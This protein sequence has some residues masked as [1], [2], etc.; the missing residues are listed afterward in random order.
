MRKSI[1]LVFFI[2]L[3]IAQAYSIELFGIKIVDINQTIN[4]TGSIEY[5]T[6]TRGIFD[7][8]FPAKNEYKAE[9]DPKLFNVKTWSKSIIQGETKIFQ[10]AVVDSSG[11]LTYDKKETLIIKKPFQNIFSLLAMVQS[12]EAKDIDTKWFNYEHEGVLGRARFVWADSSNA[13]NGIDSILCDHYRLDIELSDSLQSI[14][15]NSD[16]FM[17]QIVLDGIIK[18]LWVSRKNPKNII[19]AKIKMSLFPVIA[20]MQKTKDD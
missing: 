12:K 17:E 4:D 10:S 15:E 3:L 14:N 1:A 20:N 6:Q 16:Y 7:F 11:L 5:T 9:Y 13:W 8:I 18:E 19:V 2:E